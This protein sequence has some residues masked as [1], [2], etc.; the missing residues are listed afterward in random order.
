MSTK[1]PT[2][3]LHICLD[4]A[5]GCISLQ[6]ENSQNLNDSDIAQHLGMAA[7]K[8]VSNAKKVIQPSGETIRVVKDVD[9]E[10]EK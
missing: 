6:L 2:R 10:K 9:D 7:R 3:D 4:M 8:S 5:E 1:D